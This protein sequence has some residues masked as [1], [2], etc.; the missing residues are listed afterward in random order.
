M[1]RN[2][3]ALQ[4]W[5]QAQGKIALVNRSWK[6]VNVFTTFACRGGGSHNNPTV[7]LKGVLKVVIPAN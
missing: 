1:S 5:I 2:K 7:P 3:K 4:V 6:K